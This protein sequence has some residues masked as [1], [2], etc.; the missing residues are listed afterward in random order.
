M[1]KMLAVLFANLL[2]GA[3]IVFF[4]RVEVKSLTVSPPQLIAMAI[5]SIGCG[6]LLSRSFY[7]D[8]V[9]FNWHAVRALWFDLPL[10]LLIGW[11]A[12]RFAPQRF[13]PLWLPIAL[14]SGILII[15][16]TLTVALHLSTHLLPRRQ[17]AWVWAGAYY[18]VYVWMLTFALVSLR[19]TARLSRRHGLLTI[20]PLLFLY[21]FEILVPSQPLWYSPPSYDSMSS[22]AAKADS[23]TDEKMLY[24]QPRLAEQAIAALLPHKKGRANLYF[25]G[26]APYAYEDVFMKESEVIRALM[27]DR[28]ETRGRSLL[29]VNNNKTLR[30]YPLATVTNLRAALRHIGQLMNRND[31]VAVIY[32]TSH[33]SEKHHLS[34]D[35]WPLKL[36]E[37]DPALL[38]QLLDEAKIKWRVVIVSACYAG[39]FVE[40][41]K[42]PTTL[43]MTA[44]D[45]T[46]TSFG[47][48]SESNF[49]YFAKALFDE[50]LRHTYSF[51]EAFNRAVPIIRER[52]KAQRDEFSNPQMAVGDAI[53]VKLAEI[54]RRLAAVHQHTVPHIAG[55]NR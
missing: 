4:R 14:L 27:D 30:R 16:V 3:R 2:S 29:L 46:H 35:Y 15:N 13:S 17:I 31:D 22:S 44:A 5:L 38:K 54:A 6:V 8:P 37:L 41:L 1:D 47:C 23:P 48:G 39:G 33:G 21:A 11:M 45:A 50:Q 32:L 43:V 7:S 36:D 53:H 42:G 9:V 12:T 25:I 40:P 28:F 34:S 18:G 20:M 24:L 19:R 49:T 52:E 26:F 10:Y 55:V 51:E